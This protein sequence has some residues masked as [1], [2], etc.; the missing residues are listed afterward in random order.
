MVGGCICCHRGYDCENPMFC[1]AGTCDCLCIRHAS[2]CAVDA[3]HRGCGM[4]TNKEEG[5][6]CKIGLFCCD[7]GLIHPTKIC[8]Y[9]SK[10]LCCYDVGSIPF[11]EDY[12]GELVCAYFCIQCA[13]EC[14]CCAAPPE[15][16]AIDKLDRGESMDRGKAGG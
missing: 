11:D 13:P 14:G 2:C 4:T 9:A 3:K 10:C 1:S 5:G 6:I 15:S 8:A 7:L 12:V 16:P